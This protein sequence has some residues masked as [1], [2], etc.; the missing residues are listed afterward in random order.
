M[1]KITYFNNSWLVNVKRPVFRWD[2]FLLHDFN[3]IGILL[4]FIKDNIFIVD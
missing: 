2:V 1:K 4:P 3:N